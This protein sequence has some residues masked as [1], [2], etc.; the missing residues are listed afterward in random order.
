[1]AEVPS[2]CQKNKQ[3]QQQQQNKT[4]IKQTKNRK[5]KK[6]RVSS[7]KSVQC[8]YF[9]SSPFSSLIRRKIKDSV[10]SSSQDCTQVASGKFLLQLNYSFQ[11][12]RPVRVEPT[13]SA[14]VRRAEAAE[15]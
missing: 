5:E 14:K 9:K 4:K 8:L 3:Q 6:D 10:G 11:G 1:V 13:R 15:S 2:I 7:H 12:L